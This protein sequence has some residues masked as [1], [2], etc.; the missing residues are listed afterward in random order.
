M[1]LFYGGGLLYY[2]VYGCVESWFV[3]YLM[4]CYDFFEL[5]RKL[6]IEF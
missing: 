3:S 6:W 5:K 2:C 1:V 4:C